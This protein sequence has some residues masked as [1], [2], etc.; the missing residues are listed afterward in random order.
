MIPDALVPH[1]WNGRGSDDEQVTDAATKRGQIRYLLTVRTV[2]RMYSDSETPFFVYKKQWSLLTLN[3]EF[4]LKRLCY[5]R[6]VAGWLFLK[7]SECLH[8]HFRHLISSLQL[9]FSVSC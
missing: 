9:S 7:A 2:R 1:L 6:R 8:Q 5:V 3:T 4:C